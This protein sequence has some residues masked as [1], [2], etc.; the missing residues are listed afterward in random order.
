MRQS[1]VCTLELVLG[2]DDRI[3]WLLCGLNDVEEEEEETKEMTKM[4]LPNSLVDD[5]RMLFVEINSWRALYFFEANFLFVS[6]FPVISLRRG[7]QH[8]YRRRDASEA[9]PESLMN[10]RGATRRRRRSRRR[11]RLLC[12]LK[13]AYEAQQLKERR[14]KEGFE[15]L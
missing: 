12:L 8:F 10:W 1:N 3:K 9:E 13:D 14:P 4:F 5:N 15:Y 11:T 7:Y 2:F 6:S